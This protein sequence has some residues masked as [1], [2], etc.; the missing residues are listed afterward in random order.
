MMHDDLG[1]V[2]Q[3]PGFAHQ[4]GCQQFFFAADEEPGVEPL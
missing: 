3:E 2:P 4:V 1:H